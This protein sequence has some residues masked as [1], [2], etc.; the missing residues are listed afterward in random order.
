MPQRGPAPRRRVI[1][2]A[3]ERMRD[4]RIELALLNHRV[5]GRVD[6][7]DGDL[8]CLDVLVRHGS[9]TPTELARRTGVHAATMTGILNRLE[10]AG[11]IERG[12]P[13]E[14]RRTVVLSPVP[15]R[16][17]EVFGHYAGMN[18]SLDAILGGYDERELAVIVDFLTRST[19]AG[20]RA[21]DELSGS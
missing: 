13:D 8:D 12:R 1:A 4:L 14:D 20:R 11:W 18:A 10:R 2:E 19:E 17:R 3:K 5:G 6:L 16:V 9:M 15:D 21:T 7:K